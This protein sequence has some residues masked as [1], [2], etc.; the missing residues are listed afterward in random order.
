MNDPQPD[1]LMPSVLSVKDYTARMQRRHERNS[2]LAK[3]TQLNTRMATADRDRRG[4]AILTDSTN[5][6]Q[7]S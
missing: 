6:A 5:Y 1:S 4:Q 7:Y 2:D 3:T